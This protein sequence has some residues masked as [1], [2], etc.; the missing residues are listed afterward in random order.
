MSVELTPAM[1]ERILTM[2]LSAIEQPGT[3]CGAGGII[4]AA[5]VKE[6]VGQ[7]HEGAARL[8]RGEC[9]E[10]A[11]TEEDAR[12]MT[13]VRPGY[14]C[15]VTF[16]GRRVG[17]IGISGDPAVVRGSA[18]IAARVMELE[19][20]NA[21]AKE[22]LRT[23]AL[24]GLNNLTA[25]AGQILAGTEDHQRLTGELNQATGELRDRSR[26]TAAA[27]RLIEDLAQRANLLGLN[28]A[29]EAAHA[30]ST[31]AG[32]T[33]VAD[34]IR[35]LADRTRTSAAEVKT[36]LAEW[37]Q[38]FEQMAVHVTEAARVADEQATAI[39]SVVDEIRRVEQAVAVLADNQ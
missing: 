17:T 12:S 31:G 29:V 24:T 14:N 34:E 23:E 13:G 4:Y 2:V 11:I 26:S 21:Q 8:L 22:Q 3:V 10:I 9:D 35:K 38:S 15:V 37:Q 20:R 6:R 39:R 25:A 33:V 16:D 32:F 18:R 7:K 5:A 28:A 30:G 27:M 1:A 36:A 19:L